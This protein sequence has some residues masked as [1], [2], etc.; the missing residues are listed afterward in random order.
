MS[1][2]HVA[3]EPPKGPSHAPAGLRVLLVE[4]DATVAEVVRDLL[5]LDG[6]AVAGPAHDLAVACA[7]AE[8]AVVDAALLDVDLAGEPVWPAADLLQRRGIPFA[9]VTGNDAGVELPDRFAGRPVL[10]K[11][12]RQEGL[13]RMVHALAV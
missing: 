7:V 9:F 11:P 8:T 1:T 5:E 6:I 4:D 10:G 12:F 3:R 13:L 2:D